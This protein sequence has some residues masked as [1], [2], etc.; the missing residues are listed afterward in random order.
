MPNSFASTCTNSEIDG[1]LDILENEEVRY[2][3]KGYGLLT[4]SLMTYSY[5][6]LLPEYLKP[7]YSS[8]PHNNLLLM[9][10]F[11]TFL[12]H[13]VTLSLSNLIMYLIYKS[14]FEFFERYRISADPWPWE[15]DA[16]AFKSQLKRTFKTLALNNL[17]LMPGF[18]MIPVLAGLCE[19]NTSPIFYPSA[20]EIVWQIILFMVVE[21]T[22]FYWGH[23]LLHTPWF[24]KRIHKQHHEYSTT[25]GLAAE[26]A[27]PVEFIL[28]NMLPTGLGATL[29]GSHCHIVTW[30][31]WMFI[32]ILETTDGHCG[33]EFS[34]SPFRLLPLS[35]SANYHNFHHSSNVGNFGSFFTYWDTLCQTNKHY[36]RYLAKHEKQEKTC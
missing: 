25:V 27:H 18:S 16:E 11:G 15:K 12:I 9:Y 23:R 7:Y 26:Y 3:R 31:M 10:C 5:L 29:I 22:V 14:R 19:V 6:I 20:F 34:W 8:L 2:V 30:Y 21:D 13:I 4:A 24:Y 28:G 35:G 1:F 17:V 33:Y 36:W 32:R